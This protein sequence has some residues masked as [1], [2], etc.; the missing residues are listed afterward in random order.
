[1]RPQEI[2]NSRAGSLL[3][4]ILANYLGDSH[5]NTRRHHEAAATTSPSYMLSLGDKAHLRSIGN[6]LA[7]AT[8]AQEDTR[9][10]WLSPRRIEARPGRAWLRRTREDL[11]AARQARPRQRHYWIVWSWMTGASA[12]W[13]RGF[14]IVAALADPVGEISEPGGAALGDPGGTHARAAGRHRHHL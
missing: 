11:A 4:E 5:G 3:H 6:V 14:A 8:T 9:L 12:P 13:P 1:M 2:H 10:C 7:G